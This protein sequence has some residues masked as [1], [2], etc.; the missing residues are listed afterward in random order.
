MKDTLT[1]M[2]GPKRDWY[3][4]IAICILAIIIVSLVGP[5]STY[6]RFGL[7]Q[8]TLYWGALISGFLLPAH[9]IRVWVRHSI[10]GSTLRRDFRA[11]FAIGLCLAPVIWWV[12]RQLLGEIVA[13]WSAFFEHLVVIWLICLVPLL[14]RHFVLAPSET[15]APVQPEPVAAQR[16]A[17]TDAVI[18]LL[19]HLEPDMRGP[20][21]RVSANDRQSQIYTEKGEASV[22]M[23]FADVL[24]QLDGASGMQVHRSHWLAFDAIDKLQQDGRRYVAKLRCG[25]SVPV[26]PTYVS[27]LTDAGVTLSDG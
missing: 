10:P 2:F 6:E 27:G 25:A 12:N 23:R 20:I 17:D 21:Q 1:G 13:G 11:V 19:R 18:P 8:R 24:I 22:R 3:V 16:L 14:V 15:A 4:R 9:W 26:S 5:F 7:G